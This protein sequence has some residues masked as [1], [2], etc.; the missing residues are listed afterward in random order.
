MNEESKLIEREGIQNIINIVDRELNQVK[1][2]SE[3]ISN[4]N[5]K[6]ENPALIQK[7]EHNSNLNIEEAES[8]SIR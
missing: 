3:D 5:S 4:Q 2:N 8:F 1:N 6:H 7:P